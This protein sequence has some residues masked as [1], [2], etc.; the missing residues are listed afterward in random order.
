MA[1]LPKR[2]GSDSFKEVTER[3]CIRCHHL[4]TLE[5]GQ[6]AYCSFCGAPQ[7][8]LSEALQ[9]QAALEAQQ[10]QDRA[11][12][13]PADVPATP[14]PAPSRI[15][16]LR[17]IAGAGRG[18]WPVAVEFALL[19]SG[20]ALGLDLG[21]LLFGPLLVLAWLWMV[22]APML[23]VSFYRGRARADELSAGFAARLGLLTG[24]LVAVSCAVVFTAAL[25]L[26]RF[27]LHRPTIDT[28]VAEAMGQLRANAVAQYGTAAQPMLRMLG[29]PEFRVGLLLWM[30]TVSA[31]LYLLLSAITAGVAGLLLG[32]RKP[33]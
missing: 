2:R 3:P 14:A 25:V 15:A 12:A 29:I 7:V 30:C 26:E 27:V 10:Y 4:L 19:S 5:E 20:I 13:P 6:L 21:G 33:A 18:R 1:G 9:E 23:T 22:S 17:R 16:A 11:A 32:R 31:A 28:Q 24:L 8:F